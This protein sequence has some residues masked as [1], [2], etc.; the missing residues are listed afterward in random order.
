MRNVHPPTANTKRRTI[1]FFEIGMI[2]A[3]SFV[4]WAF[5]YSSTMAISVPEVPNN[6]QNDDDIIQIRE[7]TIEPDVLVDART[8]TQ[9]TSD[10]I[11]IVPDASI[12]PEPGPTP[13]PIPSIDPNAGPILQIDAGP[14]DDPAGPDNTIVWGASLMPAFPGGEDAMK[15][16]ITNELDYPPLAIENGIQGKVVVSFVIEKDGSIS[17]VTILSKRLGWGI[18]EEAIRVVQAMPRWSPGENNFRP[19]RVRMNLPIKFVF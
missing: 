19:V 9:S 12:L 17:N 18:E 10:Q 16:F 11:E 7:I 3:L 2:L 14:Q 13:L 4:L 1:L 6:S 15:T 5:N 8:E